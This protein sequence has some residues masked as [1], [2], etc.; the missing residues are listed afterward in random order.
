MSRKQPTAYQY[1]K[2]RCEQLREDRDKASEDYDRQWYNRVIEELNWVGM[3]LAEP[4]HPLPQV[5]HENTYTQRDWD[6][7][8]GYGKVP[9]EYKK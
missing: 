7:T 3:Y 6:R 9:D 8:V 5:K 2:I 1:I 4:D